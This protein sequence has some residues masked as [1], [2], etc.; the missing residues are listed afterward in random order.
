[1]GLMHK[2]NMLQPTGS[3][4]NNLLPL[5]MAYVMINNGYSPEKKNK[6]H[7]THDYNKHTAFSDIKRIR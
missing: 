6:D 1:M 2:L 3:C 7:K 5:L 4:T